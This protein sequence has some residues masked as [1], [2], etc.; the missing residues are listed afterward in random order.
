M[1]VCVDEMLNFKEKTGFHSNTCYAVFMNY[2]EQD[3][4]VKKI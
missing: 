4:L 3:I 1:Y 2:I